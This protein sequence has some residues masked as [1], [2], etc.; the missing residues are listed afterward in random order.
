MASARTA[1]NVIERNPYAPTPWVFSEVAVCLRDSI[2]AA[3]YPSEHLQQRIDPEA[4]S[5]VLGMFPQH[6]GE[7]EHL[8]PKRCAIFNFEQLASGS[9]YANP[10]YRE[11]LANWMVIDYHHANL[12]LLRRENGTRQIAYELPI[13]PSP[14]LKTIGDEPKDIDVL[15]FGSV[16]DRRTQVFHEIE[17]M[18]LRLEVVQ[19]GYAEH[20][21][22][23]I[24]RAKLVLHVHFYETAYFPVARML[25]PVVMGV[26]VICE[27]SFHSDLNDW[28]FSGIVFADYEHLAETCRDFVEAPERRIVRARMTHAFVEHI[29]FATPF[30][31]V[32]DAFESLARGE[33]PR[34]PARP[35][36]GLSHREIAR[37]LEEEGAEPPEAHAPVQPTQLVQREPGKGRHGKWIVALL[38]IFSFYTIWFSMRW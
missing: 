21:A 8:D 13:V 14:S 18:G 17:A 26:P 30:G 5:I 1:I 31:H 35:E 3:G 28:S 36:G 11:W 19:G 24:R 7:I 22:S 25:Q 15:F 12:A 2:R 38:L 29:D 27:S 10:E 37:I 6:V 4:F 23:L 16:N 34:Q 9:Q 33:I 20:L 32:I